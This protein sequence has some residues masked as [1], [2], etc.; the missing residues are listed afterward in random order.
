MPAAK[1]AETTKVLSCIRFCGSLTELKDA[2][3]KVSVWGSIFKHDLSQKKLGPTVTAARIWEFHKIHH[4]D[5]QMN[6][7]TWARDHFL[8]ESW[9]AF[10]SVSTLGMFVDLRLSE[11]GRAALY[12]TMFLVGLSMFY[13]SAIRVHLPVAGTEAVI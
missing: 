10:F 11:A 7:T 4:S 13:H 6:N 9:R 12:S 5:E 2:P 1:T 3:Q 8:P